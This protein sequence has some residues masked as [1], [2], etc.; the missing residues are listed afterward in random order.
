M[1]F[2]SGLDINSL[3]INDDLIINITRI[4]YQKEVFKAYEEA[5]R[6]G[7]RRTEFLFL[8]I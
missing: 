3:K 2:G 5:L 7:L 4:S 8:F 6:V 1:G